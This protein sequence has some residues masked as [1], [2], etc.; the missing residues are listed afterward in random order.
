MRGVGATKTSVWVDNI[1]VNARGP[2]VS[3]EKSADNTARV[4]FNDDVSDLCG[5]DLYV[6]NALYKRFF[7]GMKVW[8]W[9]ARGCHLHNL[10][11][12]WLISTKSLFT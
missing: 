9:F 1:G 10:Q 5:L 12:N 3:I 8:I 6:D 7:R 4:Q 2:T 11:T